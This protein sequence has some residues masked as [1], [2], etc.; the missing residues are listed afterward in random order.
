MAW[1]G[2]SCLGLA[3]ISSLVLLILL[4]ERE[5][6]VIQWFSKILYQ[7]VHRRLDNFCSII[8]L[9]NRILESRIQNCGIKYHFCRN[10]EKN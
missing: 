4:L 3:E 9:K 5:K 10:G 8:L 6:A 1:G 7:V 2:K